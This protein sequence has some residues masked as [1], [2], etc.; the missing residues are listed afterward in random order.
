MGKGSSLGSSLGL[1]LGLVPGQRPD[2]GPVTGFGAG[3]G[4][5]NR[6][7]APAADLISGT[8]LKPSSRS[9]PGPQTSPYVDLVPGPAPA[10]DPSPVSKVT[11]GPRPDQ[12]RSQTCS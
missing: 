12:I 8:R 2:L 6:V 7:R 4:T 1:G 10:K 3:S 9:G 11:P 5:M